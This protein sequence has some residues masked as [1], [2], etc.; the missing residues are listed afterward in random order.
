M[1][2]KKFK[3]SSQL[4]QEK[5]EKEN[6]IV[7]ISDDEA[8]EFVISFNRER[9]AAEPEIKQS[10]IAAEKELATIDLTW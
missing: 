6:R 3:S 7:T 5:L 4:L 9:A 1:M 8:F 2:E 10:E